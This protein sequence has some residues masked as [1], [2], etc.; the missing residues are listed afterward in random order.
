MYAD[1]VIAANCTANFLVQFATKIKILIQLVSGVVILNFVAKRHDVSH[2][3]DRA[4][5]SWSSAF[6]RRFVREFIPGKRGQLLDNV[7]AG[8]SEKR[9]MIKNKLCVCHGAEFLH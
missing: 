8:A 9:R 3:L 7:D 2:T 6:L 1:L 5:F 4:K